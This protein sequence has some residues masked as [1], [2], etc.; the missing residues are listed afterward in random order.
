MKKTWKAPTITKASAKAV[1]KGGQPNI[2]SE[3]FTAS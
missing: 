1:T 3:S 2:P